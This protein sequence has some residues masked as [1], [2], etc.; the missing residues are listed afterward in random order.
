MKSIFALFVTIFALTLS[1]VE[2]AGTY[3]HFPGTC[4]HIESLSGHHVTAVYFFFAIFTAL[5]L[6]CVVGSL[7]KGLFDDEKS[8]ISSTS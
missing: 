8:G 5:S 2:V 3:H 6:K 1:A 4:H 7:E